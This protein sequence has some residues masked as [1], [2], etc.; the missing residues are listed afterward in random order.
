MKVKIL[1]KLLVSTKNEK[2]KQMYNFSP[3]FFRDK[4]ISFCSPTVMSFHTKRVLV[5]K[6]FLFGLFPPQP[7]VLGQQG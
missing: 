1:R 4:K 7:L 3:V 5:L 2:Y 6:M